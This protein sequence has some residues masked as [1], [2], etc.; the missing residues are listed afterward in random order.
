MPINSSERK[1]LEFELELRKVESAV[2][3]QYPW[4]YLSSGT[5]EDAYEHWRGDAFILEE[6]DK[7]FVQLT[8]SEKSGGDG[9]KN[10]RR[11]DWRKVEAP[12]EVNGRRR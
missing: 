5:I 12:L 1:Q 6:L 10:L 9:R 8:K 2:R 3:G 4:R 7:A 11:P